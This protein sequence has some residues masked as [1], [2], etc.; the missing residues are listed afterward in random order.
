MDLVHLPHRAALEDYRRQ[1]E[2]LR[3]AHAAR[4]AGA[5]DLVRRL[6]PRLRDERVRWL[7]RDAGD[8]EVSALPFAEEHARACIAAGYDFA[9]WEALEEWVSAVA[10]DGEVARYEDAV[11]AVID[12]DLEGLRRL[13]AAHAWLA[14]ERSSRRCC[15]DPPLHRATLLHYV[16]ANGVENQRQ[17]TPRNAVAIATALL[18]AG[19]EPDALA[20]F[21]G[22]PC[23]TLSLLVSSHHPAAAG[24]QIALAELLVD[25]GASLVGRGESWGAPLRTALLFGFPETARALAE[26]GAPVVG[27]ADAA[28]LGRIEELRQRVATADALDRHLALS[29]AANLGRS[30]CMRVLLDAGE[31][32]DRYNPEGAHAHATP[33][34]QA[35]LGGHLETVRLLLERGARLDLRDRIYQATPLDWARHAGRP[36]VETLLLARGA[37]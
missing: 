34:H 37:G 15:F 36:D 31:S 30:E 9:D 19:A 11:E 32:P 7:A 22:Q 17:R 33:L 27:A 24:L 25:R 2:H 16:A 4:E 5:L 8:D 23:A 13:L 14:R 20:D 21:Y 18:D 26:R 10:R 6:D 12:G 35:A 28:G 1:A 3:F 29:F